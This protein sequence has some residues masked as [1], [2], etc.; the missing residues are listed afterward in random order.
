MSEA[1]TAT[2]YVRPDSVLR[3]TFQERVM[4]WVTA[5]VYTYCLAT[6]LAFYTPYLFWLAVVLG[7]GSTSR[8]WHPIAG[9]VFVG[10]AAWMHAVWNRDMELA[11][12]D[13]RWLSR[14]ED[15]AS[16]Q[17]ELLPLQERFNAGQK[18]FYWLMFYGAM[19]LL[20]SGL[21]MWFP[22]YIP[23]QVAWVRG[24]MIVIHEIAALLT[25]GGFMLHLYM[26]LFLVPGSM[27]AMTEGYV[28][29]AWA[30]THHRL[31]YI[32]V[33]GGDSPRKN[34]VEPG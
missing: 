32:R 34:E 15:Y 16:N 6:G 33:T 21:F 11:E 2:H 9:L 12:T 7:G 25:L 26:G 17:D 13:H 18:L 30:R 31:W 27:T 20:L 23:V 19:L 10:A 3:Y 28:S 22:E 29:R 5:L 4:H 14:V 1:A 8:F 24:A